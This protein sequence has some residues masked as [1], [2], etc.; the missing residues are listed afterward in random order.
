MAKELEKSKEAKI[1]VV[2]ILKKESLS[3]NR[4]KRRKRAEKL[5]LEYPNVYYFLQ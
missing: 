2:G 1:G 4:T 5:T 3:W